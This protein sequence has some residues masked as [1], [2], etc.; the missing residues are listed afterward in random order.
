MNVVI[1]VIDYNLPKLASER[2]IEEMKKAKDHFREF[3]WRGS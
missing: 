2:R 1:I 3:V